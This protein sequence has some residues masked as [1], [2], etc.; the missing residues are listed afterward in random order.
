MSN[1]RKK[2]KVTGRHGKNIKRPKG[3]DQ[4]R[5]TEYELR[6]KGLLANK[7]QNQEQGYQRPIP[8]MNED[9]KPIEKVT[10]NMKETILTKEQ[11]C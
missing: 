2:I 7:G 1:H 6:T 8:P 9:Q 3:E 4:V 5:S 10:R 11:E